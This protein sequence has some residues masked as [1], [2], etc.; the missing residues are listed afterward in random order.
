MNVRDEC[1]TSDSTTTGP[2]KGSGRALLKRGADVT[3]GPPQKRRERNNRTPNADVANRTPGKRG[4]T[5]RLFGKNSLKKG[6][7]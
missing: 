2:R 5:V 1:E 3:E 7:M 4:R 6:T